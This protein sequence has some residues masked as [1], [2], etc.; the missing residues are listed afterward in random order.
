[1][2]FFPKGNLVVD[3]D[4]EVSD[5]WVMPGSQSYD[6]LSVGLTEKDRA[7][8]KGGHMSSA[9]RSPTPPTSQN[10]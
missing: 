7:K 6:G 3:E 8:G 5:T 10:V 4:T 2:I 1:M 9:H